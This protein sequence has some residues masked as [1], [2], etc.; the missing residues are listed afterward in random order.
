MAASLI[1]LVPEEEG[2]DVY[3]VNGEPRSSP[4]TAAPPLCPAWLRLCCTEAG[5]PAYRLD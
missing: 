3:I 1:R 5:L 2:G 4:Q